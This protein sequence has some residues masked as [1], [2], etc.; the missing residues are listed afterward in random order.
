MSPRKQISTKMLNANIPIS[1]DPPNATL[2]HAHLFI[3]LEDGVEA[4][5]GDEKRHDDVEN[6]FGTTVLLD[7]DSVFAGLGEDCCF[8]EKFSERK[9]F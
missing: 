1:E 4:R 9:G 5:V 8:V 3:I 2:V 7:D 6:G